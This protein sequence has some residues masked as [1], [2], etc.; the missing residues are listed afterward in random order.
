[1]HRRKDGINYKETFSLVVNDIVRLIFSI[2]V[3]MV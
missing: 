1:M 3:V 2:A